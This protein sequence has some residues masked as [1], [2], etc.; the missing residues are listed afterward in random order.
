M[1]YSILLYSRLVLS[2]ALD[3]ESPSGYC[4]ETR[5]VEALRHAWEY[6]VTILCWICEHVVFA[7]WVRSD[8]Q[9][10]LIIISRIIHG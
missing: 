5:K 7:V 9:E 8:V 10:D 3:H 4:L 2:D 6:A 1:P